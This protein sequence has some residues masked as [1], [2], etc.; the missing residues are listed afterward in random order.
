MVVELLL[1]A[2]V[3]CSGASSLSGNCKAVDW[4]KEEEK[5]VRIDI[6]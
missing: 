2:F 5:K 6:G 3:D 1:S 4:Q